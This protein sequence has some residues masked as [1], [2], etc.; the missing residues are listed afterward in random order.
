MATSGRQDYAI[1][2]PNNAFIAIAVRWLIEDVIPV[3]STIH[4]PEYILT[5]YLLVLAMDLWCLFVCFAALSCQNV[6]IL[7]ILDTA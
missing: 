1:S 2:G 6:L 5:D 4:I 7:G 3:T